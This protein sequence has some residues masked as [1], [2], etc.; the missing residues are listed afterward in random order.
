VGGVDQSLSRNFGSGYPSDP[1]TRAW[2]RDSVDPVFGF[3][4]VLRFSWKTT[5]QLLRRAA[6]DVQW[7]MYE[8]EEDEQAYE[9]YK[10][11]QQSTAQDRYRWF[12]ETNLELCTEF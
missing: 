12:A 2:L 3:P 10:Q 4:S 6:V 11:L 5:D 7:S 9:A 8:E 1:F